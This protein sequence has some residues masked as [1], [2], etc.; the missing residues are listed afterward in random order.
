MKDT[1][2]GSDLLSALKSTLRPFNLKLN[3]LSGVVTD[4]SSYDEERQRTYGAD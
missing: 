3:N 4:G 1:T 2:K